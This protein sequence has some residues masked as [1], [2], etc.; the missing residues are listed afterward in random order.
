MATTIEDDAQLVL[1][2]LAEWTEKDDDPDMGHYEVSGQ[3]LRQ[4]LGISPHRVNDAVEHLGSAGFVK[5]RETM[6]T[7]PF[8]FREVWLEAPGR[9]AYQQLSVVTDPDESVETEETVY[10]VF[11][12]HS[13]HDDDFTADVKTLLEANGIRVFATPGSVPTGAWE[14]QIEEALRTSASIW[15]ILTPNALRDSV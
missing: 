7:A 5:R 3:E 11:L 10:D 4:K 8:S 2:V 6:G 14:P 12:S 15:V 9:L 13:S 1:V